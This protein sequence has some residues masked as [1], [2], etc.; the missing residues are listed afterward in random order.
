MEIKNLDQVVLE[1]LDFFIENKPPMLDISSVSFPF[2]IGSVNAFHTG[3]I[4]FSGK[5]AVF[6]D[7]SS[8]RDMAVSYQPAIEK[9]LISEAYIIS[10][11]GEKDSVWEVEL[12]KQIGLKTTLLTCN[13]NSS[14]AKVADRVISY[15]N[16]AE[17]YSYNTSTYMGMI[18]SVTGENPARIKEVVEGLK[19]PEN[20]GDYQGYSFVIPDK[21]A[22][23]CAM[24][25]V[26]EHELF[27]AHVNVRAFTDGHA[28]HAKFI[29]RWD[30][31]LVISAGEENKYYGL[32]E[33]RWQIELPA[34]ADFGMM[35]AINYYICGK[36]QAAKPPYFAEQ[37]ENFCNDYG[38]KPY[39]KDKP[40]DVIV[41]G[42]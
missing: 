34:D 26:K 5:A 18:L 11:S 6:A 13:P 15:R 19:F 39:G 22:S 27:A 20:F 40:F 42:N 33:H 28:R 41:P 10:A 31:E 3:K 16:I 17:P 2:V 30:K 12:A 24:T 7:E 36:I 37:V 35:M 23:L 9:G 29:V 32:P 8:F 21:Y 1:A 38:P 25:E 4:L 14:A